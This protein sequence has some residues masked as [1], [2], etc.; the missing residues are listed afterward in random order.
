MRKLHANQTIDRCGNGCYSIKFACEIGRFCILICKLIACAPGIRKARCIN[1]RTGNKYEDDNSNSAEKK[2][3]YPLSRFKSKRDPAVTLSISYL[4]QETD[5]IEPG[6]W[7]K[8]QLN[9]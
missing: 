9:K 2:F 1:W 7:L 8:K 6:T 5:S 3:A 4:F